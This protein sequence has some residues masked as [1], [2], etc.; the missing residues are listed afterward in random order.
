MDRRA[1]TINVKIKP[2]LVLRGPKVSIHQVA[3][4][5]CGAFARGWHLPNIR[6]NPRTELAVACDVDSKVAEQACRD[7]GGRQVGTDWQAVVDNPQ[8]GLIVLA[9]HTGLREE[10]IIPA[11]CAGKPV[12]VEK[13][14][15]AT[16]PAMRDIVRV[17]RETGVPV[18][19]GHNR[20]SSQAMLGLK[21]LLDKA[22][23]CSEGS[24][25]SVDRREVGDHA[26]FPEQKQLMMLIRINDDYRSW[27]NWVF[28]DPQG[29]LFAEMVHFVDVAMW[30]NPS[31]PVRVFAEGSARGNFTLLMKFAD[32][33]LATVQHTMVGHF[34]YPK[35][36]IEVSV[37]NVTL[38]MDHHVELRQ[39]GLSDENF[40]HTY[41]FKMPDGSDDLGG[42][43]GFH[44]AVTRAF[45]R[46]ER[47]G[48][49]PMF[50]S[51]DKGHAAHLDRF[52]DCIEGKAENPCDVA[53]AVAVTRVTLKLL[54]SISLE[55]SVVIE[56]ED[57]QSSQTSGASELG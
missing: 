26:S 42:I 1:T 52:L 12:Y 46:A 41:A 3:V 18:C 6:D 28:F 27:K 22:L 33:S 43:E 9:T 23:A 34:D 15:A 20:R 29:I 35:E 17:A 4:V 39:R 25:P 36:L 32:G 21:R 14:L 47:T 37:N 50:I 24:P 56:P 31:P 51:P 49:L 57:L 7:F 10:L 16:V 11:L 48:T 2:N 53:D 55:Q 30:L 13:P 8:V 38:A 44:A 45:K 54:E 40:R 19:V 5:G